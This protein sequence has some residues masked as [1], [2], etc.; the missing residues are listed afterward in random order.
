VRSGQILSA[1]T[2]RVGEGTSAFLLAYNHTT[3]QVGQFEEVRRVHGTSGGLGWLLATP[4]GSVGFGIA[5]GIILSIRPDADDDPV[6]RLLNPVV[7]WIMGAIVSAIIAIPMVLYAQSKL[8]RERVTRFQ[9]DHVPDYRKCLQQ[10]TQ[11]VHK[12]F[13]VTL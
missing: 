4:V 3:G 11:A 9:R 6:R 5:F 8:A 1:I 2:R 13:G 12:H 7:H 10:L